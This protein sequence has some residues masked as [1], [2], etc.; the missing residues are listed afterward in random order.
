MPSTPSLPSDLPR[1][2]AA[3]SLPLPLALG[4]ALCAG[5]G[6][7]QSHV[8]PI[9]A[10]SVQPTIANETNTSIPFYGHTTPTGTYARGQYFYDASEITDQNGP[11][12][13]GIFKAM[14]YRHSTRS[15]RGNGASA[16]GYKITFD[17]RTAQHDQIS[18]TF[19]QNQTAKST[20]VFNSN[21]SFPSV[22]PPG[23]WPAPWQPAITF[24]TPFTYIAS[25]GSTLMIE[26]ETVTPNTSFGWAVEAY[27]A[28]S[29]LRLSPA[30]WSDALCHHSGNARPTVVSFDDT[31]G[32]S[33]FHPM[34]VPGG[35]WQTTVSPY[36]TNASNFNPSF[37]LL[38]LTGSGGSYLGQ[39]LPAPFEA[40]GLMSSNATNCR[41]AV[42]PIF[43]LPA[44]YNPTAGTVTGPK[45][46][47]PNLPAVVG[48]ILYSQM[49][50]D[51]QG[52]IFPSLSY[53]LE[54][55]SG[56]RPAAT[57]LETWFQDPNSP[58]TAG[59]IRPDNQ[60]PTWRLDT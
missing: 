23:S 20:V 15:A 30:N 50:S 60:I 36:P 24:T 43:I 51:D 44:V 21:L 8:V 3:R 22:P 25:L 53:G 17:Q 41:L 9:M 35:H 18:T 12:A 31:L 39:T 34:V 6:A 38:G 5:L 1:T 46:N 28:H 54:V 57:S 14:A 45:I 2:V 10:K 58:P 48:T 26:S 55:G 59:T 52:R 16:G 7:Q 4:L 40:L 13:V 27:R 47:I 11:L 37:E 49:I 32:T 19:S 42:V 33:L 56:Q 29:G